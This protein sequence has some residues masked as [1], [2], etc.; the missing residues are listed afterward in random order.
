MSGGIRRLPHHAFMACTWIL[1]VSLF[2]LTVSLRNIG[3]VHFEDS[4]AQCQPAKH[5]AVSV[6]AVIN[7]CQELRSCYI[8]RSKLSSD[9]ESPLVLL[10][11]DAR[12]FG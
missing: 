9:G 12:K 3:A 11:L 6:T 5:D 4:T 2:A 10:L 8:A 7:S 1:Y